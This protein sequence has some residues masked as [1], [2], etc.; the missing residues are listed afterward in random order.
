MT[1]HTLQYKIIHD[2]LLPQVNLIILMTASITPLVRSGHSGAFSQSYAME[3]SGNF[4]MSKR[5]GP[6][7]GLMAACLHP[8][9]FSSKC[10]QNLTL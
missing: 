2:V 7:V 9:S 5:P 4:D 10:K 8:R 6:E 3:D 1:S